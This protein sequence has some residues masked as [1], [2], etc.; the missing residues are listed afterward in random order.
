MKP[1]D[2]DMQFLVRKE[3]WVLRCSDGDNHIMVYAGPPPGMPN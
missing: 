3:G 2:A 1:S